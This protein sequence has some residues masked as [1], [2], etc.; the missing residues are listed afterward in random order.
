MNPSLRRIRLFQ[1]HWRLPA[2]FGN[3]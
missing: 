3:S 2:L 1:Q